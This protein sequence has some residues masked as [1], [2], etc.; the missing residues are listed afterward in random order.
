MTTPKWMGKCTNCGAWDS[1]IELN[2]QQQEVIKLT[3]SSSPKAKS[4]ARAI[5]EVTQ[6]KVTR[7]TSNDIELDMVLGGGVVPGSLTLI[8]GSPGVG[9]STLLLKVGANIAKSGK[10][11]LYVTGEE[12]EGQIKLRADRLK[13]AED[14]LY[15]LSE[16]KLEQVLL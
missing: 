12:S 11:T 9:K 7:F 13:A 8:G 15:L 6:T 16:I 10:N 3:S 4:K 1:L 14:N 2:E 5:K